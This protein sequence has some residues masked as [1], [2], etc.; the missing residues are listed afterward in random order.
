MNQL[1][2]PATLTQGSDLYSSA[3]VARPVNGSPN[4]VEYDDGNP[5]T[6]FVAPRP[7]AAPDRRPEPSATPCTPLACEPRAAATDYDDG[8]PATVICG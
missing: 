1:F 2:K 7:S 3:G 6:I 5:A 8:N 4:V